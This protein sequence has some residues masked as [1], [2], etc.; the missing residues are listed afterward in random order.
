MSWNGKRQPHHGP[1]NSFSSFL[2]LAIAAAAQTAMSVTSPLDAGLAEAEACASRS[3]ATA[4]CGGGAPAVLA[5]ASPAADLGA[6]S[7]FCAA[8]SEVSGEAAWL[9]AADTA[10]G[11][12]LRRLDCLERR[13]RI[14]ECMNWSRILF[15]DGV[16]GSDSS[17]CTVQYSAP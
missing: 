1:R 15:T 4:A 11:P 10:P 7:G 2:S 6:W 5:L 14:L 12:W 3:A 16:R 13:L 9:L 8:D 17:F